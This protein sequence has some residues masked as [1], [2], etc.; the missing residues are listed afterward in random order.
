MRPVAAELPV[1]PGTDLEFWPIAI[2]SMARWATDNGD[3][4]FLTKRITFLQGNCVSEDFRFIF[5]HT[6]VVSVIIC[7]TAVIKAFGSSMLADVCQREAICV[8]DLV[9]YCGTQPPLPFR[10][11][12]FQEE[13]S[14]GNTGTVIWIWTHT[15]IGLMRFWWGRS[16]VNLSVLCNHLVHLWIRIRWTERFMYGGSCAMNQNLK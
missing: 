13:A 8:V 3:T 16:L 1:P 15:V 11:D 14:K 6:N 4:Y 7:T 10:N 5:I 2:L 12:G 9:S